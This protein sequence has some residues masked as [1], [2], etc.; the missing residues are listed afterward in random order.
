MMP[1]HVI[2][3]LDPKSEQ[4]KMLEY[5]GKTGDDDAVVGMAKALYGDSLLSVAKVTYIPNYSNLYRK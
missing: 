1:T 5:V 2:T 4:L 3:V